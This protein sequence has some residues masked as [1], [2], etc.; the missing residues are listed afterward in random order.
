MPTSDG[1]DMQKVKTDEFINRSFGPGVA[2]TVE[3]ARLTSGVAKGATHLAFRDLWNTWSRRRKFILNTSLLGT[4]FALIITLLLPAKYTAKAQL[5][6]EPDGAAEN[7][8]QLDAMAISEAIDTHLAMLTS[9]PFLD[10]IVS[11]LQAQA[12][13]STTTPLSRFFVSTGIPSRDVLER[14][15][16]IQQERRSRVITVAYT[17]S[18]PAEAAKIANQVAKFYVARRSQ[19]RQSQDRAEFDRISLKIIETRNTMERSRNPVQGAIENQPPGE[20]QPG[21]PQR[22]DRAQDAAASSELIGRLLRRQGELQ[23]QI[24]AAAAD[25]RL[26]SVASAPDRPSSHSPLL[27]LFPAVVLLSIG[28]FSLAHLLERLDGRIWDVEDAREAIGLPCIG[29]LPDIS[30][31]LTN[32]AAATDDARA[33]AAFQEVLRS[34]VAELHLADPVCDIKTLLITSSLER[35]G[36]TTLAYGLAACLACLG[37]KAIVVDCDVRHESLLQQHGANE[38]VEEMRDDALAQ[39]IEHADGAGHDVLQLPRCGIDPMALFASGR[40]QDL[41]AT[42]RRTYDSVVIDGPPLLIATEARLLPALADAT[43]IAVRWGSTNRSDVLSAL[44][45]IRGVGFGCRV[46]IDEH[47]TVMTCEGEIAL[48]GRG[49]RDSRSV[50]IAASRRTS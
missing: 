44:A 39:L 18:H 12:P 46:E 43:I 45:A 49:R 38:H 48:R 25:V 34:L 22:V 30:S 6:M 20:D 35:E 28:G 10:Y 36:R 19:Q 13:P 14:N 27:F 2:A 37:R 15:L 16:M 50:P 24:A 42:L 11:E 29:S 32:A 7:S 17:A 21:D 40:L 4:L 1:R 9:L 5:L 31:T 3:G 47:V 41:F 23:E 33:P 8:R 26:L